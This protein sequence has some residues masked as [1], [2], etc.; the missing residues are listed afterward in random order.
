M[1]N[2]V[3][4]YIKERCKKI[5]VGK[6][7]VKIIKENKTKLFVESSVGEQFWIKKEVVIILESCDVENKK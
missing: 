4:V 5:G 3:E 7:Y 2:Y 6:R 1:D